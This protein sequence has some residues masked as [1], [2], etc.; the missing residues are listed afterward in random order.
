MLDNFVSMDYVLTFSG[1][2]IL[3]TLLTQSTKSLFDA[4]GD[5]RTKWIVYGYSIILCV[6]AGLW[7]GSFSTLKEIV[8]MVVLTL[9][10]SV[11]VWFTAMKAFETIKEVKK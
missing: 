1:M 5:N 8:E 2:I 10:N 4:I 7:Q 6:I 9:I 3:V 11:I